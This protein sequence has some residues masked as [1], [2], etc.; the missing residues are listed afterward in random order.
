MTD[1]PGA[2]PTTTPVVVL[3]VATEVLEDTQGLAKAAVGV[4]Y[5]CKLFPTQTAEVVT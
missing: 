4:P 1:V 3:M 2:T 5:N